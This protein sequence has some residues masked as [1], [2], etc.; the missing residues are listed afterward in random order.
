MPSSWQSGTR[1][2][3][4]N[5]DDFGWT[6]GIT[7]AIVTCH[8]QGIVTSA[9]LLVNQAASLYAIEQA[10]QAPRLGI[11]THLNLCEGRP[12]LAAREAPSLVGAR[13]SPRLAG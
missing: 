2:L 12:V 6:R 4:V 10:K 8:N 13:L 1:R 7:D 3:I 5:A 9:A 11:G